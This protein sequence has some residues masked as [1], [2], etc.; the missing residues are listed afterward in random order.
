MLYRRHLGM[1]LTALAVAPLARA[2]SAIESTFD[3]VRRTRVVRVGTVGGQASNCVRDL[4][5]GEWRG[6][7]PAFGHDLAKELDS[8]PE[9]VET[10]FGT[11]VLALQADKIDIFFGVN[12]LPQRTLAIDFTTRCSMTC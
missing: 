10:N 8:M 11:A 3:R 5:S 9:F 7:I 1:A 4:A 2:E 12:P 6:F